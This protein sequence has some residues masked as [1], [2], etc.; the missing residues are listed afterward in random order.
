MNLVM[1]MVGI[2]AMLLIAFLL[3]DNCKAINLQIVGGVF[4]IQAGQG[5]SIRYVPIDRDV[6]YGIPCAISDAVAYCHHGIN[7]LFGGLTSGQLFEVF[8][9]GCLRKSLGTSRTESLSSTANIN[10]EQSQNVVLDFRYRY[11]YNQRSM[12]TMFLIAW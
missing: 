11:L 1:S 5:A 8:G 7:F 2:I 3:S 9:G 4:V 6:L 10:A 12:R